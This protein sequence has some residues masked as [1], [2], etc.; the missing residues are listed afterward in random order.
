M[1]EMGVS[2]FRATCHSA[3]QWVGRRGRPISITR[4]GKP[5][6]V[7]IPPRVPKVGSKWLGSMQGRAEICGDV[8]GPALEAQVWKAGPE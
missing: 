5:L 6:A 7:L 4:F 1:R 2:E 8:I 3:L